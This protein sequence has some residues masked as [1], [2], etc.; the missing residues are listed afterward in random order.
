MPDRKMI[1]RIEALRENRG[2]Q[3]VTRA[4]VALIFLKREKIRAIEL[5]IG[6]LGVKKYKIA[7]NMQLG[8]R[9]GTRAQTLA[10]AILTASTI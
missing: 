3:K 7:S 1:D 4:T 2:P 6:L 8:D 10:S 9:D 5:E